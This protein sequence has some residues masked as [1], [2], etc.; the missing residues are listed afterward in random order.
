METLRTREGLRAW[1]M[2][3]GHLDSVPNMREREPRERGR[4]K[5]GVEEGV[6]EPCQMLRMEAGSQKQLNKSSLLSLLLRSYSW[7]NQAKCKLSV[8]LG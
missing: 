1:L 5:R 2:G 8:T 4:E 3:R 7:K 6:G